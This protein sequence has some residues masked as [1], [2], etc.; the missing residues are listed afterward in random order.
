MSDDQSPSKDDFLYP[1]SRYRGD[2]TPGNL[3]FNANLQEFAQRVSLICNLETGGKLSGE[4]AYDQIK[5]LWKSLKF[6]K[7]NLIDDEGN[8]RSTTD[9]S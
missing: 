2:F 6:S 8:D 4:E 5:Q 9:R 1:K 7:T 3:A